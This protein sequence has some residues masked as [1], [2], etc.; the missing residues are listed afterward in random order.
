MKTKEIIEVEI[1]KKLKSNPEKA[2]A[3][4]AI[5]ELVITGDD[6]GTWSIDC[7]KAGGEVLKGSTDKAKLT[8]TM[9]D[10][11]FLELYKGNLNP[12]KAFFSGKV[13]VKGDMGLALKLGNIL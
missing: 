4:N 5:V 10:S 12:Q 9:L 11:D 6:G 2:T 1:A 7:T 3:V 8:V 13:K